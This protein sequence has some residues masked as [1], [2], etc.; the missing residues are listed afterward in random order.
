MHFHVD[1]SWSSCSSMYIL[2]L[3]S[4]SSWY[5]YM[6][7]SLSRP[8]GWRRMASAS[9][10]LMIFLNLRLSSNWHSQRYWERERWGRLF[11]C[12]NT[13]RNKKISHLELLF[14]SLS[15]IS[16]SLSYQRGV[17]QTL[18]VWN[19]SSF[20][21]WVYFSSLES[22]FLAIFFYLLQRTSFYNEP[23]PQTWKQPWELPQDLKAHL[24]LWNPTS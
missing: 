9:S 18:L 23:Y 16:V 12:Q 15:I 7:P 14:R 19:E 20:G 6:S 4:W 2:T 21:V 10:S 17:F 8:M 11:K 1:P 24:W 13:D 3:C 22:V 5:Q